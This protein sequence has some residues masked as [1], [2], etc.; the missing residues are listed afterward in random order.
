MKTPKLS[1]AA[2]AARFA[3][4]ALNG[5]V[6]IDSQLTYRILP[7]FEGNVTENF[8]D[9]STSNSTSSTLFASARN[10]TFISYSSDFLSLTGPDPSLRLI[11]Q[12]N[13]SFANEAGIW[14]PPLNEVWFTSSVI[15]DITTISI[16]SLS[17]LSVSTPS[18]SQSVIN[19]NGGYYFAS[20]G[21]ATIPLANYSVDPSTGDTEV[22]INSYFG[23]PLN[24]PNDITWV[25]S[26][27]S[28]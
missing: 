14:V 23:L 2:L 11:E 20:D 1:L 12:R 22:L 16:L 15:N 25:K 18:L 24:G 27:R 7:D 21:N 28:N 6:S 8:I 3:N 9:T 13:Y 10:A 26:P 19:A 4:A 17:S 5:I